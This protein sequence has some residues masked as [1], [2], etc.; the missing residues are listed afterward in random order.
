MWRWVLRLLVG[1]WP[2]LAAALAVYLVLR[3]L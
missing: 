3:E 2:W 1:G